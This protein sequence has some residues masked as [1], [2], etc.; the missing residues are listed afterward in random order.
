MIGSSLPSAFQTRAVLSIDAVTMRVPSG[1]KKKDILTPLM[2]RFFAQ[3]KAKPLQ[4][5]SSAKGMALCGMHTT[6]YAFS[7]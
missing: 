3:P 1:L 5:M 4:S 7:F 2:N 6:R